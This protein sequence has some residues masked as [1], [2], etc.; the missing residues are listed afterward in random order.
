MSLQCQVSAITILVVEMKLE[1]SVLFSKMHKGL[2][3]FW[4]TE[5]HLHRLLV[6][7]RKHP[8]FMM[9]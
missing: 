5:L 2:D 7:R 9:L 4:T 6:I 8:L 3:C 1:T